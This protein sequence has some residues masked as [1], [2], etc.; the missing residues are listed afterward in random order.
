MKLAELIEQLQTLAA[1]YDD[2]GKINVYVWVNAAEKKLVDG[3]VH[4]DDEEA[5]PHEESVG[6]LLY[7]VP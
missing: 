1:A 3:V 5:F 4:D 7:S 2:P 6:V